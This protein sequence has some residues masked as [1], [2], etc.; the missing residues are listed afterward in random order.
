MKEYLSA[1]EIYQR[2]RSVLATGIAD[3]QTAVKR[4]NEELEE[5][6]LQRIIDEKNRQYKA[7]RNR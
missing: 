5:A 4:M 1:S 3:P 7:W 6:G 2:Y